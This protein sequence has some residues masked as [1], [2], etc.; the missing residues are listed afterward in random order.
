MNRIAAGLDYLF[1]RKRWLIHAFFWLCVLGFY[2]VF[3]GRKHNNYLQTFFFVGLL[4][5]VTIG[6]TYLLNYFLV[7]RYLMKERYGIFLLYFTYALIGSLLMAM[8]ISMLTLIVMA[9][10]RAQAMSPASF[11]L[12]FLLTSLLM[13]VFLAVSIKMMLHWRQSK[14][15][16]QQLMFDKV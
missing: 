10:S 8:I 4:L 16:L 3:F 13:V 2:V 9:G 14:A 1:M 5:P 11:D 15:D 12:I 6:F 7:P